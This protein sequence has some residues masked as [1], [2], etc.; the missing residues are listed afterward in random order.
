MNSDKINFAELW[1]GQKTSAPDRE[2]IFAKINAYQR[3]QKRKLLASNLLLAA[4]ALFIAFVW[5]YFKPEFIST[6]FGIVLI[7]LA[8]LAWLLASN[9]LYSSLKPLDATQDNRSHLEALLAIQSRQRFLHGTMINLYFLL[10]SA[11][12]ALYLFEYTSRMP[13]VWAAISYGITGVWV[14]LNWFVFRPRLI[15]KQRESLTEMIRKLEAL[16]QQMG[17]E[18]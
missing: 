13:H 7:L 14:L 17:G 4:T 11:G 9:K 16:N 1:A 15:R 2:A 5:I 8:I 18:F 3:K 10:L 12:L 6:K